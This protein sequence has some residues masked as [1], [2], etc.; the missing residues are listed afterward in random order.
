MKLS[1]F[2]K[3]FLLLALRKDRHKNGYVDFY[4][5]PKK[6]RKIVDRE[7]IVSP[8]QLLTDSKILQKKLFL[9]GYDKDRENYLEKT[10]L[11]M[12][13]TVDILN[14][15]EI[16]IKQQFLRFYDVALE[17]IDESELYKLKEEIENAYGESG[18]LGERM[19]D[20]RVRRTVP[21]DKVFVLFNRALKIVELRTKK[22]F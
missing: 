4:F 7:S 12:R 11:A 22:L 19:N 14:D 20:L 17:P 8:K 5:G 21:R 10:L 1:E 3:T 6:L 13:T 16:P 2:G 15:I 18:N 9:Q